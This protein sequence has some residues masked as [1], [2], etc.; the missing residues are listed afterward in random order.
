[1][2]DELNRILTQ[3]NIRLTSD[4]QQR[5]EGY[6]RLLIAWNQ[7]MDLT[8]VPED[9]MAVR[10]YAD[11]LLPL[12][13]GD[14]FPDGASLI[15]VGTGAG[16]PGMPIAIA[17][18]DMRVVLLDAQQ[19]RCAFLQAVVDDLKLPNV[20]VMHARAE[21][22]AREQTLRQQMD[23]ACARAV[24]PA[25]VLLEYLLPFVR[26]GGRV[27]MWKGPSLQDEMSSAKAALHLLGGEA[28]EPY[29]M[30]LEDMNL[31]VQPVLK[32]QGTPAKYPRRAGMP[33][34]SPL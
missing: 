22:A 19:K 27:L 32:R 25:N 16:F 30:P 34:K 23:I 6:H 29:A 7:R 9:Q 15:D 3:A 31:F 28:E 4:A 11:S 24:A 2:L 8:N 12:A 20:T 33:A 10:H 13:H 1:M 18:P 21:G 26:L 17:R 14:W 5:M